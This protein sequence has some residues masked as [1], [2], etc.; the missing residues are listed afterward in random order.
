MG[1]PVAHSRSPEM[2]RAAFECL[3]LPHRYLAFDVHPDR[4]AAA[5]AAAET[6]GFA[7]LNLTVPH[8]KAAIASVHELG[9]AA[10]RIGAVNTVCLVE[11]KRYGHNTDGEGFLAG[12]RELDPGPVRRATVLGTGGAS[13]AVIDAILEAFPQ[14][15]LRWVGRDPAR[16]VGCDPR[17]EPCGY[18]D[19]DG[20]SMGD[21]IVNA[22]TVGMPG[23]AAAFPV[24][25]ALTQVDR[26]CRV[27]DLVYAPIDR[28]AAT[29][30]P[31]LAAAGRVGLVAQD[32]RAMLLWQ[33]VYALERWLGHPMPEA[34][35]ES[36]RVT[37]SL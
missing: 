18:G 33:G 13:L 7:G 5:I 20:A 35:V 11:G 23:A 37:L 31:L 2:H 36:M 34:V 27:V 8:K 25:I 28:G 21:L 30:T 16:L 6:L 24:P 15:S 10:R 22:S 17:V 9:A 12:L 1:H 4:L 14:S 3:G 29:Q 19:L 32:G 26:C